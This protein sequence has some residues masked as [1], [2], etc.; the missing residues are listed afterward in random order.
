M[1]SARSLVETRQRVSHPFA[2]SAL[3]DLSPETEDWPE[4]ASPEEPEKPYFPDPEPAAQPGARRHTW[5][6]S[7]QSVFSESDSDIARSVK[8]AVVGFA[9]KDNV[10]HGRRQ[11]DRRSFLPAMPTMSEVPTEARAGVLPRTTPLRIPKPVVPAQTPHVDV[12]E[13]ATRD[14]PASTTPPSPSLQPRI[15]IVSATPVTAAAPAPSPAR[16]NI[17]ITVPAAASDGSTKSSLH[18]TPSTPSRSQPSQRASSES[19]LTG[20]WRYDSRRDSY[21]SHRESEESSPTQAHR[22]S[23]TSSRYPPADDDLSIV[24]EASHE[25]SDSMPPSRA[26]RPTF[27]EHMF[28]E[29][30]IG[31]AIP[32][33]LGVPEDVQESGHSNG[34]QGSNRSLA[35]NTSKPHSS[36]TQ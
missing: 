23:A 2:A 9:F 11:R 5:R 8:G 14:K 32:T 21:G 10:A 34:S 19:S 25:D 36:A 1:P 16:P 33:P 12:L 20:E 35:S 4:S 28:V 13:R 29:G 22:Q 18:L 31:R 17:S 24:Y 26:H 30:G 15:S 6:T 7:N 3:Q 27:G